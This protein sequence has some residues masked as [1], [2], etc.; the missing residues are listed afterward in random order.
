MR[1]PM[2]G[3]RCFVC[4]CMRG[5]LQRCRMRGFILLVTGDSYRRGIFSQTRHLFTDALNS[6][7]Y[8]PEWPRVNSVAKRTTQQKRDDSYTNLQRANAGAQAWATSVSLLERE[9][10]GESDTYVAECTLL[11]AARLRPLP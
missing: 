6:R 7:E 11:S 2:I 9:T 4:P 5:Q 10:E 1:M 3:H 8:Y